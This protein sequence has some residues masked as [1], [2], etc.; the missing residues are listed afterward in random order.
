MMAIRLA[1]RA[2]LVEP[3]GVVGPLIVELTLVATPEPAER[4]K[5]VELAVVPTS[6][7]PTDVGGALMMAIKLAVQA[8]LAVPPLSLTRW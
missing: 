1:V 4:P 6:M 5:S 7:E 3:D 8:A 2:A